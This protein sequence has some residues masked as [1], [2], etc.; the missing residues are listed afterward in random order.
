MKNGQLSNHSGSIIGFR[1][2]GCLLEL[3]TSGLVNKVKN[4][5]KGKY[6]NATMNDS[7]YSLMNYLYWK[8]EN[9]VMLIIDKKNY[10]KELESFIMD[11]PFN[12]IGLI[13]TNITEVTMMLNTGQLTYYI[14][15][16]PVRISD[17]NSRYAMTPDQ[18]NKNIKRRS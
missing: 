1:C 16:D 3:N 4:V 6:H 11:L 9:T 8:T 17:V 5:V 14:D 2:E 13:F 12:Q 7:I 15:T 18:F 10:T